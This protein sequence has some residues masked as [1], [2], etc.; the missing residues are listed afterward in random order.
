MFGLMALAMA[1]LIMFNTFRTSVV[2]RR[3]DIGMLRAVGARR[4]SV[5]RTI[6]YEGSDPG[7]HGNSCWHYVW[8]WVWLFLAKAGLASMLQDL[9]GHPLGKL[10]FTLSTYIVSI[11]FWYGCAVG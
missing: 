10:Q 5:M 6:L 9:M 2:E 1:G 7:G 11:R 8:L 4:K 3:R